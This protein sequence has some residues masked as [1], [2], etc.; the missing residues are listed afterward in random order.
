MIRNIVT[1]QYT[2]TC[3]YTLFILRSTVIMYKIIYSFNE[4][5][6]IEQDKN[7]DIFVFDENIHKLTNQTIRKK[8][9]E[10]RI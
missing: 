9:K 8:Y 7:N 2:S 3:T 10:K 4:N 5:M 6:S 1:Q